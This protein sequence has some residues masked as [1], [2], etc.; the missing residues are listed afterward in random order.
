MDTDATIRETE[1]NSAGTVREGFA[2]ETVREGMS[3]PYVSVSRDIQK[4]RGYEIVQQL[5]T[6]GSES[7]IFIIAKNSEQ[8]ILKLYRY[9]IEPKVE[10]INK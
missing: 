9:K 6:S 2:G 8:F 3:E 10:I 4:F 5:P 1:N 7:D